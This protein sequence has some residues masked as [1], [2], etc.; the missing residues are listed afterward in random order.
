MVSKAALHRVNLFSLFL[1]EGGLAFL[2]F[3]SKLKEGEWFC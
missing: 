1:G 3:N 2:S